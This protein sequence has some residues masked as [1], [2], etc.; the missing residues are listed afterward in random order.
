MC[1][2][3]VSSSCFM[4]GTRRIIIVTYVMIN[5]E[6]GKESGLWRTDTYVFEYLVKDSKTVN[7]PASHPDVYG[8]IHK[9]RY[10]YLI[11]IFI[12][13][14]FW[15]VQTMKTPTLTELLSLS[16]RWTTL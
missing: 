5:I 3:N 10:H 11:N 14:G 7:K 16:Y 9:S 13:A 8:N 15:K 4:C 1:S 2:G 12:Q 6:R